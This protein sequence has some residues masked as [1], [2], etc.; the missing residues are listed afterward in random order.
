MSTPTPDPNTPPPPGPSGPPTAEQLAEL[1]DWARTHI[2]GMTGQLTAAQQAASTSAAELAAAAAK[3][4]AAPDPAAAQQALQAA[5]DRAAAAELAATR[6]RLGRQYGLPD[7]LV[8]RLQGADQAAMETDAK[9]LAALLPAPGPRM[10]G[11]DPLQG[12]GTP[13]PTD[14]ATQFAQ[15]INSALS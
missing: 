3:L 14:P 7:A 4:A 11:P 13:A 2:E 8:A 12:G 6:E 1:P 10:P 15:L 9:A 5:A